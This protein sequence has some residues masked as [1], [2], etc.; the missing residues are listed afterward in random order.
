MYL[1]YIR[2]VMV[3]TMILSVPWV[4]KEGFHEDTV[5]DCIALDKAVIAAGFRHR[6]HL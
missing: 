3:S 2:V 1:G 4:R 5:S 6:L